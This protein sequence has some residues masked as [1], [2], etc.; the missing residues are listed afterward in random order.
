MNFQD[1]Q[2][3]LLCQ[4]QQFNKQPS[5]SLEI[6]SNVSPVSRQYKASE[7]PPMVSPP[8]RNTLLPT[9]AQ[10]C[11]ASGGGGVPLTT[12][13]DQLHVSVKLE[14]EAP[15]I[16]QLATSF[17]V[18]HWSLQRRPTQVKIVQHYYTSI[19]IVQSYTRNI[20][21]LLPSASAQHE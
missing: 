9:T 19:T 18:A 11:A 2:K 17:C 5:Q 8:N 16:L 21:S 20:M 10:L 12:G 1:T 14:Q 7:A 15:S 6:N 13:C 4:D 3:G